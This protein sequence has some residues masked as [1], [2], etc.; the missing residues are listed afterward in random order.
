METTDVCVVGA[1]VSGLGVAHYLSDTDMNVTVVESDDNVGGVVRSE[2][3]DGRVVEHGPQRVRLAGQVKK[4][5]EELGLDDEVVTC[6][7]TRLYFYHDGNLCAA[8]LSLRDAS[9]TDL[10][11]LRGKARILL[12]PLKSR[13]REDETVE[14]A[15]SRIFGKEAYT[16]FLGPLYS[17]LYAS[18][19]SE[20]LSRYS[21][22]R[23][24]K[25]FDGSVLA[26]VAS[27]VL[28]GAEIPPACTFEDGLHRLPEAM[29]EKLETT[30]G[31][32]VTLSEEAV[33]IEKPE[34]EANLEEANDELEGDGGDRD[35]S[36]TVKTTER[37]VQADEVVLTTPPDATEPVLR[38]IDAET[39]ERVGSLNQNP[40][41]VVHLVSDAELD[42]LGHKFTLDTA[43]EFV[44]TGVTWNASAFGRDGVYTAYLGGAHEP[45]AVEW[46]DDRLGDV[47]AKEFEEVTGYDADALSVSRTK[48]PAYDTSWEKA[49]V[50]T[51]EPPSG[52]HL[53]TN[54]ID[55]AGIEGRLQHA[56]RVA[57]SIANGE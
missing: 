30:S 49:E 17:G 10:L 52:V 40:I 33:G 44:T 56:R 7:E 38:S 50:E 4:L 13:P 57:N 42:G 19:P 16:R 35:T 51:L 12:E 27:R 31:V 53:C 26:G 9:T 43:D 11:S 28:R 46:R 21:L 45:D 36:Y 39:A 20:M 37:T 6:D 48:I 25:R 24:L 3:I 5:V 1:G 14:E 8:P 22:S 41:V 32:D 18:D 55:R 34:S 54:Y 15:L 23:A 47:A 2:H 29:C